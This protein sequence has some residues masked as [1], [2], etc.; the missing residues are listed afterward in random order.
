MQYLRGTTLF[1]I[2]RIQLELENQTG[3]KV[4]GFMKY[5]IYWQ[6]QSVLASQEKF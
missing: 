5:Q 6:K 3:E 1:D 4:A 2:A